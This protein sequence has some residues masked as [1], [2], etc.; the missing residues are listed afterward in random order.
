MENAL[1]PSLRINVPFISRNTS[2][3]SNDNYS[4]DNLNA[5]ESILDDCGLNL[6]IKSGE[7]SCERNNT[8]FL[9][10]IFVYVID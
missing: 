5:S 8:R 6:T 4:I 9:F 3:E 2:I 7:Y 10:A 1:P